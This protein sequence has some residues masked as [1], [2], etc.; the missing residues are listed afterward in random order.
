MSFNARAQ[1]QGAPD[2]T[3]L[4]LP[5]KRS[6]LAWCC[7]V[8]RRA[9]LKAGGTR[10]VVPPRISRHLRKGRGHIIP[11]PTLPNLD[12]W[13]E[14]ISARWLVRDW[15]GTCVA[16]F[17]R[18]RRCLSVD[19]RISA[20]VRVANGSRRLLSSA[21]LG[22]AEWRR[23]CSA[24]LA[25]LPRFG[26]SNTPSSRLDI[27]KIRWVREK[28]RQRWKIAFGKD[29]WLGKLGR[30]SGRKKFFVWTRFHSLLQRSKSEE[31]EG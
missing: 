7:A 1:L 8:Y 28:L 3:F 15:F 25:L 29:K 12:V 23:R 14:R 19:L 2:P 22:F 17:D 30:L 5:T 18:D 26:Q 31:F 10:W 16:G 4:K 6:I 24:V 13:A 20:V 9:V 27:Y 21:S 11:G